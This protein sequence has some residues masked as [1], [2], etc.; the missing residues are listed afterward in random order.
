MPDTW[1]FWHFLNYEIK[2]LN[3]CQV[4]FWIEV[5]ITHTRPESKMIRLQEQAH[6]TEKRTAAH[7]H[8]SDSD[9]LDFKSAATC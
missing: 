9:P 4:I 6:L 7:L 2:Y 8:L 3:S 5:H 1:T